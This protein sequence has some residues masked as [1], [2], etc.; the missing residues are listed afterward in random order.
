MIES[1]AQVG[2]RPRALERVVQAG[3]HPGLQEAG[4]QHLVEVGVLDAHRERVGAAQPPPVDHRVALGEVQR[5]G[6]AGAGL[7]AAGEQR[8]GLGEHAAT[9]H[10]LGE[11][12][13]AAGARAAAGP[14]T[15]PGRGSARAAPRRPA[16]PSPGAR[17]SG[18][19]R[20]AGRARARTAPGIPGRRRRPGR[21]RTP[22]PGRAS[23]RVPPTAVKSIHAGT[24]GRRT[25]PRP[26]IG[27]TSIGLCREGGRA[28]RSDAA[29]CRGHSVAMA[30]RTSSRAARRAGKTAAST[31]ITSDEAR[32][33]RRAGRP[34]R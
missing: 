32:G 26:G 27:R 1:S 33:T 19:R 11:A 28:G 4:D 13:D 6:D 17:S 2:R 14:R 10:L 20:S 18:P 29:A 34:G 22:A 25:R 23:A 16:R 3:G 7:L 12:G 8:L 5:P 30:R 24:L 15:C 9:R 21:A 31:P